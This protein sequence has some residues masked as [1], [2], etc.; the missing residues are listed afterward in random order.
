MDALELLTNDHNDVRQMFREL[1]EAQ[2]SGDLALTSEVRDAI[3]REITVHTEIEE[4]VF[5]PAVRQRGGEC[6]RLVEEGI[7]EHREADRLV[8]A[9][10]GVDPT[11]GAFADTMRELIEAV[12]HHASE[13][14]TELFPRVRESFGDGRLADLGRRLER[15][16][17]AAMAEQSGDSLVD[18][19]KEE[20]YQKAKEL[21]VDGRSKMTKDELVEAVRGTR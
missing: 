4:R 10:A 9:I 18:L 11:D 8:G 12:S 3:C 6:A 21:D 2:R 19:T 14:E 16:K 5:Y 7:E 13:E 1:Q 15:A 20:L 17:Q